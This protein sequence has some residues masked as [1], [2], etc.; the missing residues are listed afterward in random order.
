M[1]L[2]RRHLLA[3]AAGIATAPLWPSISA[4]A[5]APMV[6]DKFHLVPFGEYVPFA[7]FLNHLG[8]TKL[9]AGEEGFSSGDA[10]HTY[11][12]TGAPAV[13]PLICYEI[14]FPGAVTSSQ[15][16]GWFVNVTDDSWFGSWAGTM[17]WRS[18]TDMYRYWPSGEKTTCPPAWPPL[19]L[20]I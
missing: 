11:Q 17:R 19:P 15:R 4:Q 1:K 7:Q 8:I 16:P 2:T 18:P 5:A 6:Y 9:T 14:I 20:G 12:F 10:P 13:T 3:G